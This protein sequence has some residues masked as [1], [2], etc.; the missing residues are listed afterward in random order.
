MAL[1][2]HQQAGRVRLKIALIGVFLAAAAGSLLAADAQ[3]GKAV[4]DKSCKACHGADGK[5]NPAIGKAL[6]V[7]LRSLAS[8]DVQGKSDADL[9][10]DSVQGTGK[11][12]PT[13]LTDAQASD[14]VSYLRTLK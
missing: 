14:V 3:S 11:M 2:L 5:G 6:K 1:F 4:Y 13:K 10:K 8:A 7:E 12:K 9:K